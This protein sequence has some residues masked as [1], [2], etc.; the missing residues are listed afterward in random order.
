[1]LWGV[2]E[3]VAVSEATETAEAMMRRLHQHVQKHGQ[4]AAFWTFTIYGW[5]AVALKLSEGCLS[6]W[7][8]V[9]RCARCELLLSCVAM[10]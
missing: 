6:S 7:L 3:H 2:A 9:I 8:N 5:I 1:M 4:A 10:C